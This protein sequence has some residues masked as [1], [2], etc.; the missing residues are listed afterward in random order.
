MG[1]AREMTMTTETEKLPSTPEEA[2]AVFHAHFQRVAEAAILDDRGGNAD[3][4]GVA[5][6]DERGFHDESPNDEGVTL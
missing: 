2:L 3:A 4:L 6:G 1:I 5:D